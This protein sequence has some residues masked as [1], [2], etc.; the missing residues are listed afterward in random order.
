MERTDSSS[1]TT[2]KIVKLSHS[3]TI[4]NYSFL[5]EKFI[6]S[7]RFGSK[8]DP[9]TRWYL[10]LYPK[11]S[12]EEMKDYISLYLVLQ[13]SQ[14]SK[15]YVKAVFSLRGADEHTCKF[16]KLLLN[17]KE[18]P[19]NSWGL[20]KFI[21]QDTANKKYLSNNKLTIRCEISYAMQTENIVNQHPRSQAQCDSA[22]VSREIYQSRIHSDV[23]LSL[24]GKDSR[25]HKVTLA[26]RSPFLK[27]LFELDIKEGKMSVIDVFD[28][29][30]ATLEDLPR[31][32]Y[33]GEAE[34]PDNM[35]PKPSCDDR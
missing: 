14:I 34:V 35:L 25:A 26:A 29:N 16:T 24:D 30:E 15:V 6:D 5:S 23:V 7:R 31:F 33:T 12:R 19:K 17:T 10:R 20:H 8:G 1:K 13:S 3:W 21:L 11:G 9:G 32:I 4:K 18:L 28:M 2:R 27:C 22:K